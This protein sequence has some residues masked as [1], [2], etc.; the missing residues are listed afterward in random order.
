MKNYL[1]IEVDSRVLKSMTN[2]G[3][4]LFGKTVTHTR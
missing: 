4:V 1:V 3:F 2:I